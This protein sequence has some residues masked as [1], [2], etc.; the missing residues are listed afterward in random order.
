MVEVMLNNKPLRILVEFPLKAE[1]AYLLYVF[2]LA[3]ITKDEVTLVK[4]TQR[5]LGMVTPKHSVDE[6]DIRWSQ[7]P[8]ESDTGQTP[9]PSL[10]KLFSSPDRTVKL[11]IVSA[12]IN[13]TRATAHDH[14]CD[15]N[16]TLDVNLRG[17]RFDVVTNCSTKV[18]VNE[19]VHAASKARYA[20]RVV[21][22]VLKILLNAIPPLLFR[23][24][25]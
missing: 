24:R 20:S 10:N 23:L 18:F 5:K 17:K 22:E 15:C 13:P 6:I 25:D 16:V 21:K 7:L 4:K 2:K 9:P 14:E 8:K 3:V 11:D 1:I 12:K 19:A